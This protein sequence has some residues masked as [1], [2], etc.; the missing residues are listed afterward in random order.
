MGMYFHKRSKRDRGL[1]STFNT[2]D[3]ETAQVYFG[4][5][6]AF[7]GEK[8]ELHADH[9]IPLASDSCP[10]T[11]PTNMIPLCPKCNCAKH[12]SDPVEYLRSRYS[13][14]VTKRIIR[15]IEQF[16]IYVSHFTE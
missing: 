12:D 1:P 6:C 9:F 8:S 3:W 10:G 2:R 7:C 13:Y 15:D 16:F 11:I 5:K 14:K 4:F